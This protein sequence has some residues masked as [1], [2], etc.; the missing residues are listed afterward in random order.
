MNSFERSG[1]RRARQPWS[2]KDD[3]IL[4]EGLWQ[5]VDIEVLAEQLGRSV[6]SLVYRTMGLAKKMES[7]KEVDALL[8]A[9]GKTRKDMEE[10][11]I[12]SER[13]R[14][15]SSQNPAGEMAVLLLEIKIELQN[16]A[17]HLKKD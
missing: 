6:N 17:A 16:L 13:K 11:A 4:S 10:Y 2:E 12:Q 8:L 15:L 14:L 9:I 1:P 5:K 7:E 3:E